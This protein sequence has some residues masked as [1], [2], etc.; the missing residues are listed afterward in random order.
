[1][2]EYISVAQGICMMVMFL[3]GSAVLF[4]LGSEA[5]QDVWIAYILAILAALPLY[6]IFARILCLHENQS[7]FEICEKRLGKVIGRFIILSYFWY[8]F[9]LGSLVIRN[10]SE[11]IQIAS[12]PE[13]PQIASI[14]ML[15]VLSALFIKCGIEA[16]GRWASFFFPIVL[17][18]IILVTFLSSVE[19]NA[20]NLLPILYEGISPI[21]SSA[22]SIFTFPFA[23]VVLFLMV[24]DNVKSKNGPRN[25][26]LTSLL[27]G[28]A[29]MIIVSVRNILVL[30]VA[31]DLYYFPAFATTRLIEVGEF[32]Q[33]IEVLSAIVFVTFGVVKISICLYV[34]ARALGYLFGIDS[35]SIAFP[36]SFLMMNLAVIIYANTIEMFDWAIHIYP[37]YAFPF[38]VFIPVLIWTISEAKVRFK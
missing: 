23:E 27:I 22:T 8:S 17:T 12:F 24:L 25:I 18:V 3:T 21:I 35:K 29:I 11:F 14:T 4:G 32:I 10:F 13:T 2:K 38:Q 19:M 6:L 31:N 30:G 36:V 16:I 20:L 5:K 34:A 26:Y 37:Y 7:F 15:G 28:G 1:M 33:R 9:H